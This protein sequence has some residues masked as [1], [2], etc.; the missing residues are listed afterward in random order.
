[1][2]TA[3]IADLCLDSECDGCCSANAVDGFL[4]NVEYYTY[5]YYFGQFDESKKD[6]LFKIQEWGNRESLIK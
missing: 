4:F 2:F 5:L 1:M 6:I 3:I